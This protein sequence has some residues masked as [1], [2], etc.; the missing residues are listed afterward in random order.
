M[1]RD[2]EAI[3]VGGGP[4]GS[5]LAAALAALGHEVLLLDKA[6]FPRHKPCS[7]YVNPAGA[8]ILAQ[9]G[10]LEDA[11]A[12]GARRMDGMTV[13]APGGARFTADYA[14]A[15]DGQA[16][17]GLSRRHLDH[18]L[19]ERARA[20]GVRVCERAHVRDVLRTGERVTGVIATIDGM[21][22]EIRTSLVVG[23]DGRHSVIA[24]Q[25]GLSAPLPWPH[26]TGLAAHYR[27]VGDPGRHGEMHVGRGVYAGLALIEDGL[28]NVTVVAPAGEVSARG[29]PLDAYF[30]RLVDRLPGVARTLAGAERVGGIRGVGSMGVHSRR[31]TG[32]G[33]L[34]VGDAASFLDPFAGEGIHEALRGAL[35]AAPVISDALGDGAVS[36]SALEP[37][38]RARRRAFAAKRAVSWIVQGFINTPPAMDYVTARLGRRAD[39]AL[40]LSG[41][42]GGFRPAGEALSP[43]F[44][45]RLLRP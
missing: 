30:A 8:Q 2:A 38:R 10:V 16:A 7:D 44:L 6:R 15:G 33:F 1:T 45:A 34:L 5:T 22:E 40:T 21:H 41:V 17:V 42:L 20:A 29:E 25:L 3:V 37:Y 4:S 43:L 12:L 11:L 32:D 14:R 9:L 18:L 24:R 36:A 28:V 31:V 26:K 13:H 39:L 35:L 27:G 23:A 19:I